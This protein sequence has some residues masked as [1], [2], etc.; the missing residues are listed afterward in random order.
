MKRATQ[1]MRLVSALLVVILLLT[2]VVYAQPLAEDPAAETTAPEPQVTETEP[3]EPEPVETEPAETE[4]VETEPVETEPVETEPVETEPV[5]TEPVQT[6]PAPK[7]AREMTDEEL[8]AAY[9][10]PN[11]WARPA[12]LFALRTGL[13]NGKGNAGL[14]P[15]DY[16]TRA[17]AITMIMRMLDTQTTA[18]ISA[19]TDV[20]EGVWF[21]DPIARAAALKIVNGTSSSTMSPTARL[22]REQ[23]FVLM[24]RI[25]GVNTNT[26]AGI[27]GFTDWLQIS[28][29]AV[30][31]ISALAQGDF[32]HGSNGKLNPRGYITRQ[33]LAQVF[34]NFAQDIDGTIPAQVDGDFA[35]HADE[36]PA[37][38]TVQG[39]LLLSNEAGQIKLDHITVTGR[40]VIQGYGPVELDFD[41]CSIGT[42]VLLRP[43]ML[44][45]LAGVKTVENS[46]SLEIASGSVPRIAAWSG[47]VTLQKGVTA[48]E[49]ALYAQGCELI[50]HGEVSNLIQN[51]ADTKTSGSGWVNVIHQRAPGGTNTC[52]GWTTYNEI[53]YG[54][55]YLNGK[56]TD[57][58]KLKVTAPTI[59]AS[60]QFSNI[61]VDRDV[62]LYWY[63]NGNIIEAQPKFHL[64]EG[65]ST[66]HYV[67]LSAYAKEG[68]KISLAVRVRW[69]DQVKTFFL[70]YEFLPDYYAQA[71]NVRTQNVMGVINKTTNLY[72]NSG[73]TGYRRTLNKGDLVYYITYIRRDQGVSVDYVRTKDG[74]TGWIREADMTPVSEGYM[75]FYVTWDYSTP[76]KEAYVNQVKKLGSSSRYLIW[77]SLW[78]Q[79]VNIFTGSKGN[80]TLY[81]TYQCASGANNRPTKVQDTRILYKASRWEYDGFYVS[82]VSDFDNDGR[83]F[84]SMLKAYDGNYFVDATMGRPVSH[85]CIR[86]PDAGCQFI[87][88]N[89]PVGTTVI[90]Y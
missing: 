38:T 78:T 66:T 27:L 53:D 77:I 51:A 65:A 45:N 56:Q 34:Y 47:P 62:E 12:L 69:E 8:I 83:A 52:P 24:A 6:E 39:N 50:V 88:Y 87:Y 18:D 82:H 68:N 14:C 81:R 86:M 2:G 72:A 43:A 35:L 26:R 15:G 64:T 28:D 79:R 55:T 42:L 16:T 71:L 1:L 20:P 59:T 31:S 73:L 89:C 74:V 17:E 25:F 41:G 58:G 80:W 13:L 63:M 36:I 5:Q 85:G 75:K 33:E 90:V 23:A 57:S 22:T 76:V 21:H 49:V 60:F 9:D 29:Y 40:L 67:D 7:P 48:D 44:K 54:I 30:P 11:N 70:D 4:P 84:H 19:Y 3:V 32:I 10:V 46:E 61:P 37:G